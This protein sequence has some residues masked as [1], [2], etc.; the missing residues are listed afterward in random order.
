M[1]GLRARLL[2]CYVGL[3]AGLLLGMHIS[4]RYAVDVTI[5]E[6]PNPGV[7]PIGSLFRG[8]HA[9]QEETGPDTRAGTPAQA[10]GETGAVRPGVPDRS[11]RGSSLP[12]SWIQGSQ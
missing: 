6:R 5:R 2:W 8:I 3:F 4:H 12:G 1:S 11:E 7:S 9:T 10:D